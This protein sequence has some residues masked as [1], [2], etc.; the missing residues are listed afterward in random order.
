MPLATNIEGTSKAIR[1]AF[2]QAE[3]TFSSLK[4]TAEGDSVL[5]YVLVETLRDLSDAAR[6][7]RTLTDYLERHPEAMLFGKR[8]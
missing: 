7:I 2:E 4:R 8:G 5:G 6:S 3:K 1:T